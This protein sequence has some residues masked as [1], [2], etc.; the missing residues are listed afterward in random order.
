MLTRFTEMGSSSRYRLMQ[1]APLLRAEGHELEVQPLLDDRYL[2]VL[3]QTGSRR[4]GSVVT[5]YAKRIASFSRISEFDA[6]ICEQEMLPFFPPL[7][8]R[9]V[10]A[11]HPRFVLDY[12]D[13]AYAKYERW[14]VLRG[15]IPQLIGAA[16]TVVVGNLH[17]AAYAR[18]Y[19]PHVRV[20]P[21]VVDM[22]RYTK[23][24]GAP[25]AGVI[26]LVWIG[27]PMNAAFLG[28]VMPVIRR[29]QQKYP[30]VILRLIGAGDRI[31]T[32]GLRVESLNWTEEAE[33]KQLS[34]CDIGIMP[35]PDTEFTRGKCG[36]KLI[37]YMAVGL[38]T[39][40]SPIGANNE[41]VGENECGFLAASEADWFT[42]L[43]A[44]ICS[45]E[46]R[47]RLGAA[48]KRKVTKRYSLDYGFSQWKE[49]LDEDRVMNQSDGQA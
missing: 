23:E 12:D 20:I 5:G 9:L 25:E 3:Y 43:E 45:A 47:H 14:P 26:R 40:A 49:I 11:R 22:D 19:S 29:L 35:L 48:G 42:R 18:L 10:T 39:V 38:P 21:T 8:E 6:V 7:L 41:I 28:P 2:S 24:L 27:M 13:A 15:R 34:Q 4:W 44:L 16:H 31:P 1:Y 17:L 37:Q 30:N 36:L 46:L 33:V 32:D